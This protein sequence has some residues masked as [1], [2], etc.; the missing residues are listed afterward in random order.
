MICKSAGPDRQPERPSR[1]LASPYRHPGSRS[2][3]NRS[4]ILQTVGWRTT[5]ARAVAC[6]T[7][8]PD[9]TFEQAAAQV[10]T[11]ARR[12]DEQSANTNRADAP[13]SAID[14]RASP[15]PLPLERYGG[16]RLSVL[17]TMCA[18]AM[19]RP[20]SGLASE[21]H[22][23]RRRRLLQHGTTRTRNT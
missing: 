8:R 20:S 21:H 11:V 10:T 3:S 4:F 1:V 16:L 22:S 6:W 18:G 17:L 19:V 12:L 23:V 13:P 15:F 9:A 14:W 5:H 7:L 2:A